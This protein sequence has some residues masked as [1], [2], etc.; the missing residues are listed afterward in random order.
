M[1]NPNL[2]QDT[3]II[4]SGKIS[5][6]ARKLVDKYE[7]EK[8][9]EEEK[10]VKEALKDLGGDKDPLAKE[11][12]KFLY[13]KKI[14]EQLKTG[15]D[16]DEITPFRKLRKIIKELVENKFPSKNLLSILQQ[17]LDIFP[18]TSKEL[19]KDIEESLPLVAKKEVS[20]ISEEEKPSLPEK[21]VLRTSEEKKAPGEDTYRESIG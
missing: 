8:E 16:F 19:A 7:L 9:I 3:E 1:E 13:S 11:G 2:K 6:I 15:K 4:P 17:R 20:K 21:E 5:E 10:E 12:V 18:K 14:R